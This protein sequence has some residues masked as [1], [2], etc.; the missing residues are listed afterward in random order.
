MLK[1]KLVCSR[2]NLS[3]QFSFQ[4]SAVY[5]NMQKKRINDQLPVAQMTK[6]RGRINV[7]EHA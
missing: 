6:P 4:K 2:H 1:K 7:N 5:A 3:P